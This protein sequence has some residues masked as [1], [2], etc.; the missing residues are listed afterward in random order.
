MSLGRILLPGS[1]AVLL[2]GCAGFI[3]SSGPS[4]SSVRD[5]HPETSGIQIVNLTNSVAGRLLEMHPPQSFP[6]EFRRDKGP[7]DLVEPGDVI[8]VMIMEAPPSSLFGS[9][10]SA[11]GAPSMGAQSVTF[12]D[13]YISSRGIIYIPFAGEVQAAGKTVQQIEDDINSRLKGK[14][15][16]PQ[17]LVRLV[18]NNTNYVTVL[19]AVPSGIHLSLT[20]ARERLLDALTKAGGTAGDV[21]TLSVQVTRGARSVT[22]PMT[23]IIRQPSQNIVLQGGDVINVLRQPYNFTVIGATGRNQ[24]M[25]FEGPYITLAQAMA[26]AGG[27]NDTQANIR[28][29]FVFRFESPDALD[30]PTQPVMR[31]AGGKVRVVY[32]LD[33]S[34]TAGFFA[35]K[36]FPVCDGDLIYTAHA[37]GVGLQKMLSII[38]SVTS[39]TLGAASQAANTVNIAT[40]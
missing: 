6:K 15:N 18:G 19:G 39:P 2:A 38:G 29:V 22:V 8:E 5:A 25:Q 7:N 23:T 32:C 9:G 35:A 12:P 13:Q 16:Q 14:A 21:R 1:L 26:R 40:P 24:E 11:A 36:T 3:P 17:V 37:P 31:T 27:L 34:K 33:L 30:W 10:V 20:P 28:G 4:A